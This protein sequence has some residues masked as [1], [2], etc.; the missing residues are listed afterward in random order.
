[1]EEEIGRGE[2]KRGKEEEKERKGIG[3]KIRV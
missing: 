1:L 3:D 2:Q